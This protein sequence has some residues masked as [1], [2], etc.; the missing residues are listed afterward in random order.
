MDFPVATAFAGI[1]QLNNVAK[2]L[3]VLIAFPVLWQRTLYPKLSIPDAITTTQSNCKNRIRFA[4]N[5]LCNCGARVSQHHAES[6]INRC[7]D[8]SSVAGGK[9]LERATEDQLALF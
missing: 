3:S 1:A 2:L 8:P 4:K 5:L 7:T 6:T 9:I